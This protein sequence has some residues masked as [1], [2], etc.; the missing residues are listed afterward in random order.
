MNLRSILIVAA[1]V[2]IVASASIYMHNAVA[3]GRQ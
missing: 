2:V 3:S 1:T